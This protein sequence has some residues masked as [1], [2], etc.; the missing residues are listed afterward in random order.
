MSLVIVKHDLIKSQENRIQAFF[1]ALKDNTVFINKPLSTNI[2]R[3]KEKG[4]NNIKMKS[5]K[6]HSANYGCRSTIIERKI[7]KNITQNKKSNL[8]NRRKTVNILG[9]FEIRTDS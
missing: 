6:K 2:V 3:A 5:E 7:N 1:R 4:W 9:K 8:K